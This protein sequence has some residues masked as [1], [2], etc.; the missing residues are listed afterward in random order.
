[1]TIVFILIVSFL[2]F[3]AA[4][5]CVT[6]YYYKRGARRLERSE[7]IQQAAEGRKTLGVH[8]SERPAIWEV[9]AD[10]H[11]KPTSKWNDLL[12]CIRFAA[13][14]FS[15][16]SSD[17]HPVLSPQPLNLTYDHDQVSTRGPSLRQ[18]PALPALQSRGAGRKTLGG[19]TN[20]QLRRREYNDGPQ[21]SLATTGCNVSVFIAMPT[22]R[23]H[24]STEFSSEFAIGTA[25]VVYR[26]PERPHS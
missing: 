25:G 20:A 12:V 15:F 1:V 6:L 19:A 4:V 21:S 5:T 2:G 17:T 9:W 24:L 14:P 8:W 18:S 3:F 23:K 22:P 16:H 7:R 10:K 11:P 26:H 13:S